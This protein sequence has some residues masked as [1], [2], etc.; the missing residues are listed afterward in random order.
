LADIYKTHRTINTDADTNHKIN[1]RPAEQYLLFLLAAMAFI[2][3]HLLTQFYSPK[4]STVKSV[5]LLPAIIIII[6]LS[7]VS[8]NA[9]SRKVLFNEGLSAYKSGNFEN[10]VKYLSKAEQKKPDPI[11]SF[12]LGTA[13]YKLGDMQNALLNFSAASESTE[14]ESLAIDAAYNSGNAFF[15]TALSSGKTSRE[16]A[17]ANLQHAI[18]SY[19]IVIN[20]DPNHT[21]AIFNLSVSQKFMAMLMQ[22][23]PNN[24]NGQNDDSDNT[25]EPNDDSDQ[26]NSA[27]S[28]D[29][30]SGKANKDENEE[31]SAPNLTPDDI[32]KEEDKNNLKRSRKKHSDF[33]KVKMNW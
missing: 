11:I 20:A 29:S 2:A 1:E 9:K 25:E 6:S 7:S 24:N 17:I 18:I 31:I 14:S 5:S 28:K 30:Q 26:T 33:G 21:N 27:D 15:T 13:Y 19:Q 32:I 8:A 10:A 4:Q 12:N 3:A 16:A 23:A 22:A